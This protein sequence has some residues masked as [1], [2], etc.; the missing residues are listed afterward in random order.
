MTKKS[1]QSTFRPGLFAGQVAIVTGGGSGIGR[2]TAHELAALGA[3]IALIG[4][5]EE[6][7][8]NVKRELLDG[9]AE[10]EYFVCD[11]RQEEVVVDV[12]TRVLARF[13]RI[14][15]LVNNA[16]GQYA[17]PLEKI[18]KKGFE[19]VVSSNLTGGF[20]MA[21]ECYLQWMQAHGGAIVNM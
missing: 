16:G 9:G 15:H 13:G 10:A 18:S 21:R 3:K 11:I 4:R 20:L 7:L 17:T 8:T 5:N 1:Y 19:A 14:D 12:V 6:K 2:C